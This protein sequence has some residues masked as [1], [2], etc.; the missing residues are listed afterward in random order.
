VPAGWR[1]AYLPSRD[2]PPLAWIARARQ[3]LLEVHCGVAVR[4]DPA[5]FFE[6]SWVVPPDLGSIADSTAIFGSGIVGQSD[7]LVVVPPS[8]PLERLFLYSEAHSSRGWIISNSLA[9]L[10]QA[11]GLELDPD[12]DYPSIFVVAADDAHSSILE[13]P[14]NRAPV[15]SVRYD[16]FRISMAGAL[17]IQP[18]P[19][20]RPFTSFA[21]FRDRTVAALRSAT[22]NAPDYEMV[23]S[24]SSGYDSTAVAAMAAAAGCRKAVT[25]R[26][27]KPVRSD[28]SL[29]DSGARAAAQLGMAVESF[30]RLAYLTRD[31]L[32]EAEFLATGM[33]GEDVV[34]AA[35][36]QSLRQRMVLTGSEAFRLKGM[37]YRPPLHRGDLSAC[38]M[39]EFRLRTNFVHLPLLFF[40]ASEKRSVIRITDSAEMDAWRLPGT[41]DKPIQRRIA[42]EAGLPR[43]TF[44]TV[45]RRASARIHADGLDAMAPTSAAAVMD[46]AAAERRSVPSAKRSP[47]RSYERFVLKWSRKLGLD[48]LFAPLARRR[49]SRIHFAPELGTLLFRWSLEVVRER[50]ATVSLAGEGRPAD[51]VADL[52]SS[53]DA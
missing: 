27:G 50:Y 47:I 28:P 34:M 43:G 51:T 11:A 37:P 21:D 15:L 23:V 14:T 40:G 2:L 13:V 19:T 38:S 32:P 3:G 7:D 25:F 33:S 5:A 24:I 20:E 16:N 4:T 17:T 26:E 12:T 10:L 35:M 31:D 39:T 45:K 30:D 1:F 36:E 48:P 22:A 53:A 49:K 42:E 44:A 46:F 18:R 41:Y 8:H 52:T 29:D 9:G 6:G